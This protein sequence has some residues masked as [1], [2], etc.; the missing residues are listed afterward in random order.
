MQNTS[1]A[2]PRIIISG[3][4]TG[5]HVFPA[6]AIANAIRNKAPQA[7]ILFVGA[8]GRMEMEKVPEAGYRIEGL[9][10]SGF[11]RKLSFRNLSFPF[12]VISSLARARKIIR[13]FKP[14]VAVGVGGYA[15][16]PVLRVAS[17]KKIPTLIQEQNSFPGITNRLLAPRV[18]KICVAYEGLERFFPKEKIFF[19][20]N[21][22]RNE[23]VSLEGKR[24]RGCEFFGLNPFQKTILAV[25][26]SLGA[27][28]INESIHAGLAKLRQSGVQLIW[29]TGKPYS[30]T[31]AEAVKPYAGAGI[32]AHTFISKMD[33]AYAAADL[34]ISR[35]GAIA[36]SEICLVGKPV[37]LVPSPWVAE[38]HQTKNALALSNNQAAVMVKDQDAPGLLVE[39]AIDLL[40]DS[41]RCHQL[42]VNIARYARKDAASVIADIILGMI[43]K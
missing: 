40:G 22:V 17:R 39:T 25:G 8:K 29:Q 30:E 23:M 36:I 38:D 28:S 12:K 7:E 24:Q 35:A 1:Q 19:T 32:S 2:K 4:G 6:I 27:R 9:W 18:D 11:Q 5:G 26:G 20:G 10:I 16:G 33:Y 14:G 42:Q 31:A 34:I 37:I 21:P 43:K 13:E 41:D 3:G 15:S